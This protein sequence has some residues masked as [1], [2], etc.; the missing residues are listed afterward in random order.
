MG[1]LGKKLRSARGSDGS[2]TLLHWCP[3]CGGPHGIRVEGPA[4][5][6]RFSGTYEAPSF[7]PSILCFTNDVE[8]EIGRPLPKPVRRTLCHYFIRL[9]VELKTRGANLDDAKSYIDFC[10]DSPHALRGKIV[11]L[12]DWPYAPGEFGG[13]EE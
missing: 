13:I 4:P 12:P 1:A 6:W 7:E 8:D 10:A 5:T 2:R 11:E 9:G 3:A